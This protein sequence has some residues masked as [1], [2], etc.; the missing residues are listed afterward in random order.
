MQHQKDIS[1][2]PSLS[3]TLRSESNVP[4]VLNSTGAYGA[5]G[6]SAAAPMLQPIPPYRLFDP[7]SVGI[8]AFLGSPIA[9]AG[10]MAINY[11]RLGRQTN[12]IVAFV[13]GV[14]FT[15]LS[16]VI[17]NRLPG[18]LTTAISIG[19]FSA[20][21]R[22]AK[23]LQGP[24]VAEHVAQ[25]GQLSSRWTAAGLAVSVAA[26]LFL[27]IFGAV[28]L[29]MSAHGFG[30]KI[31][32]GSKDEVFYS[33]AATEKDAWTLGQALKETGYLKDRGASVQLSKDKAGTVVSFVVQEGVWDRP[34]IVSGFEEVG[35]EIAPSIGGFPIRVRLM[36]SSHKTKKEVGV[37]KMLVGTR[38][39]LYY[40][41]SATASDASAL[42][43]SLKS[44]GLFSDRGVTVFLAFDGGG[45]RI[46]FVVAD[47]AWEDPAQISKFEALI[48]EAA[49][50]VGGL[51][52]Q[53]RLSN[54]ELEIKKTEMVN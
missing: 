24:I 19:L 34:E 7:T 30:K 54:A 4:D 49:P 22:I 37:G 6:L 25:G 18:Y 15:A 44:G 41:G 5:Y 1:P 16:I 10:L 50:A 31:V 33:G 9:G 3:R 42:A 17:A 35:R 45:K 36:D 20:V 52:I 21:Y 48:R 51:P 26:A 53:M 28:F 2:G 27:L 13:M 12:A 39:E 47:G 38:D 11:R 29:S 40:L 23:S 32:I 43:N 14:A 8:A 46:T